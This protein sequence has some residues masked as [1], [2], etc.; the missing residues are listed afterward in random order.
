MLTNSGKIF[1]T[2][3]AI[4]PTEDFAVSFQSKVTPFIEFSN[5]KGSCM[6]LIFCFN[7]AS[8]VVLKLRALI[9]PGVVISPVAFTSPVALMVNLGVAVFEI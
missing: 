6:G 5:D 8:D 9:S 4:K 1:S 3:C 2:S 7:V